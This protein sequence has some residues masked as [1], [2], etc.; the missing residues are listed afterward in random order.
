MS[1]PARTIEVGLQGL[2]IEDLLAVSID[3]APLA[4][5]T[6]A[7]FQARIAAGAQHLE[8]MLADGG[9][10]YGV[11]TGYGDSCTVGVPPELVERFEDRVKTGVRG[12]GFVRTLP[13]T[14]WPADL[15]VKLPE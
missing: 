11:T 4:L 2:R 5:S 9:Q 14:D 8:R 3:G 1:T 12:L 13:G 10:I 15:A 6:D 7:A